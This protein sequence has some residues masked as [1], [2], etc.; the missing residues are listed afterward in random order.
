MNVSLSVKKF[1]DRIKTMNQTNSRQLCLTADEARSLHSDI[2]NMLS[3]IVE[4]T[5]TKNE[6]TQDIAGDLD[7]GKF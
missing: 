6:G 3:T 7:G 2:Y 1:N 5:Q 4:Q